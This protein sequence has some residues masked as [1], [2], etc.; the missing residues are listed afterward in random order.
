LFK[1]EMY[2]AGRSEEEVF[3]KLSIQY[4]SWN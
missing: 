3:E 4:S 1:D 2:I